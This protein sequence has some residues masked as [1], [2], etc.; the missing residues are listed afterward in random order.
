MPTG[1]SVMRTTPLPPHMSPTSTEIT[2]SAK[3]A[4]PV[5]LVPESMSFVSIFSSTLRSLAVRREEISSE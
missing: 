1:P 3:K 4:A 5:K 2:D